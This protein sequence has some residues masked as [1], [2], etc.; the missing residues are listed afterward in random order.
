MA[1][2]I[3]MED[4]IGQ[5]KDLYLETIKR[6][7]FYSIFNDLLEEFKKESEPLIKKEVER[8][9]DMHIE[10][11]EELSNIGNNIKVI[12]EWRDK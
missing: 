3:R 4:I 6:S 7:L 1:K 12:M 8:L 10:H 9:V 5:A 11:W 2:D